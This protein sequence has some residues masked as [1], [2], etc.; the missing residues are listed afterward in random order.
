MIERIPDG[1]ALTHVLA[2]HI[3]GQ[4][5]AVVLQGG[6]ARQNRDTSPKIS[7]R[8]ALPGPGIDGGE[9]NRAAGPHHGGPEDLHGPADHSR[10]R[11]TVSVIVKMLAAG[12]SISEILEAY[13]ELE[14][15]DVDQVLKYT[16]SMPRG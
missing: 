13:P 4:L 7:P 8:K 3:V 1:E 11:I 14:E 12:R 2:S 9:R 10:E 15:E 16:S 5:L 6:Q